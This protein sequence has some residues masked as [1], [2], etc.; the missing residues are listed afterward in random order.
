MEDSNPILLLFFFKSTIYKQISRPSVIKQL[1]KIGSYICTNQIRPTIFV[2]NV[3]LLQCKLFSFLLSIS[4]RPWPE[5]GRSSPSGLPF[6]AANGRLST[7]FGRA[8][9]RTNRSVA[10]RRKSRSKDQNAHWTTRWR[11]AWT[12]LLAA[13]KSLHHWQCAERPTG[14]ARAWNGSFYDLHNGRF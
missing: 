6:I 4:S 12:G 11:F 8:Q 7:R 10:E 13:V 5:A 2:V 3:N 1:D 14:E 9:A